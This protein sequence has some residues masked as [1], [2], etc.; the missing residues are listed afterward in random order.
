ML[1]YIF[2]MNNRMRQTDNV[3]Q[4]VQ[5]DGLSSQCDVMG[6]KWKESFLFLC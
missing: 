3:A 1:L 4:S 5:I 6:A 2:G